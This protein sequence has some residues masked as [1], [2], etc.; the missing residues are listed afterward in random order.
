MSFADR[1][2]VGLD[3]P[4]H[5]SLSVILR[6]M[7]YRSSPRFVMSLRP[8][9]SIP[10][11]VT[12]LA[13]VGSNFSLALSG[14]KEPVLF[15]LKR[16]R[17]AHLLPSST[18]ATKLAQSLTERFGQPLEVGGHAI[19]EHGLAPYRTFEDI[20]ESKNPTYVLP[21][22][23]MDPQYLNVA[24][25]KMCEQ[26][27]PKTSSEVDDIL[28]LVCSLPAAFD[29]TLGR[30]SGR[31]HD[32]ILDSN[33]GMS[34]QQDV[35]TL[36]PDVAQDTLIELDHVIVS[37]GSKIVLGQGIQP[38][39]KN[40]GL[41]VTIRQGSRLALLGPNG[42]GKTTL[43]SLLTSDHP[44]SYSLPIKYF[45]RSRLPRVGHPGLSL[46]DIQSRIGHSSPEIH[47]IF[48]RGLTIKRCLESAWADTFSGRPRLTAKSD[49]L[50]NAVLKW[51]EPQLNPS[52][53]L[54]KSLPHTDSALQAIQS[55]KSSPSRDPSSA[56]GDLEWA[57]SSLN[58]F[59]TLS[60]QSQRLIL[61][62]RAIIKSPDIVILDE[63]FSGF[64][65]EVRDKAMLFLSE[66]ERVTFASS[67]L[68]KLDLPR[69]SQ[70]ELGR[71]DESAR[72]NTDQAHRFMG[73]KSTQALIVVSHLREEIPDLVTEFIRLPGE[74]EVSEHGRTLEIGSCGEGE[75]RTWEGW[76]KIWGMTSTSSHLI[77]T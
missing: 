53:R 20:I 59:G 74:E 42:S 76:N 55:T 10:D 15:A 29:Q 50:V 45:G 16:W 39:F 33:A 51:W 7:A 72:V 60:F 21:S 64:S 73:L 44:Q 17:H 27:N 52:F 36:S 40:P 58:A 9:D 31:A 62:L 46:W 43:L 69:E 67:E 18:M 6:D 61:L 38:G 57:S 14:R 37:Y 68:E 75:I 47:S 77:S 8:Q 54:S 12:H 26:I 65:P 1:K 32:I 5:V 41:N 11:W 4:T 30:G 34:K 66:G 2:S 3:P 71:A 48:P 63:G 70:P 25:R 28:A 35:E 22:G 13:V 23:A 49:R 56:C 24:D 19:T